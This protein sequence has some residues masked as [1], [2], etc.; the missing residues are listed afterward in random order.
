MAAP[1]RALRYQR[2]YGESRPLARMR[3]IG[4][5]NPYA[6]RSRT[7]RSK[8]ASGL[9]P[10]LKYRGGKTREFP[11]IMPFVPAEYDRYI[12]PFF[13]GGALFFHLEPERAIINDLNGPLMG[14]YRG[15]RDDFGHVREDLDRL[16]ERYEAQR[17]DFEARKA[18]APEER[19]HD[20]N[21]DD[22]YAIRDMYNGLR[23]AEHTSAAIYY[24]INKTAYSGMIRYNAQGEYNVPYGR[25][26]HMNTA[27]VDQAHAELLQRAELLNGDYQTAFNMAGPDDF[28]FL[29]PPYDCV[30]SDYG[31]AEL[32]DGFSHEEHE[33]LA[34][35]FFDLPCRALLVIGKTPFTQRLYGGHIVH[36]YSK[37]YAVN[38][39][40]RFK[41]AS[42]HILVTNRPFEG[43]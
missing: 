27:V 25:Y 16:Q 22:Y 12:E 3:T 19:V 34:Q 7:E 33:R 39:R 41:A 8:G 30:F 17:A 24:Y 6:M 43:E 21:E 18:A 32:R 1:Q 9:K 23:Q 35:A 28:M 15:V 26:K 5:T 36:E 2:V 11:E 31:N 20:D 4:R 40:N 37:A 10:M 42:M 14:F 13:G 29:D 38:I